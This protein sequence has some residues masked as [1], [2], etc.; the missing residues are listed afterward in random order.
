MTKER[1]LERLLKLR[2]IRM[3]LSENAL[4]L[5]NRARRQAESGVDEAIQNIAHHDDVW[6]E[7]EQATIDQM[8]LQPVSSQMLAQ[9]REKMAA[10][11]QKA[12]EL[13]EAEQAAKHVLAD[14]TQR[15]QE[16]LG[17]HRQRLREHDKVLL[18]T[19]QDLEQRQRQAALQNE[20]EEEE[21]TALRAAP[22]LGRR[23]SK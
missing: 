5:Q 3:R 22:G 21:Q 13:R 10:L 23:T 1:N 16:K 6:R 15:Q 18:M 11:A 20:L 12:D 17:E 7:Q 14:E 8:G 4:L 19:R 2:R 9:E